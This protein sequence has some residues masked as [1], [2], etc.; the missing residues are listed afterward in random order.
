MVEHALAR[1]PRRVTTVHSGREV[2][3]GAGVR[4]RRI[5]GGP[6]VNYVD[7]FLLLD[8]FRS[9]DPDDYIAGFPFHP[10]RGIETVTYMVAGQ[11]RHRDSLG[12]KG[13]VGPGDVQW[14]TAGQGIIHEEMPEQRE[15]RLWG[16]QLWVNLPARLKLC[17]P[18]YQDLPAG[19]I[20][21]VVAPGGARV[22]LVAGTFGDAR[23]PV[24]EIAADPL[25]L[26]VALPRGATCA[27][28][29]PAGHNAF[30]YVYDGS[31]RLGGD[32]VDSKDGDVVTGPALALLSDGDGLHVKASQGPLR[33]LLAAGRPLREPVARGGPFVMNTHE[34]I[35][36]AFREYREG[37]FL[38][39]R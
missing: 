30:C 37:T 35:A 3:D 22:R 18:R 34:E 29:V 6:E 23:G 5:I 13:V 27:V 25:L 33:F 15:G 7:P 39:R 17:D 8:E 10:H 4:L 21:E 24:T 12:N 9:D 11:V 32:G 36:Q 38:K 26:D 19:Q 16:F 31:G 20:S 2:V 28:P 1:A 14:M